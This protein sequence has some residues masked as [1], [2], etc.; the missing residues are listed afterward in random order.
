MSKGIKKINSIK[1][2]TSKKS[3]TNHFHNDLRKNNSVNYKKTE[4]TNISNNNKF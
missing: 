1:N 3:S 4:N 2:S